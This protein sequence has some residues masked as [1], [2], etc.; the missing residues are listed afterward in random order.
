L[1]HGLRPVSPGRNGGR[2][3][4]HGSVHAAF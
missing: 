2:I 1:G 4:V 3:A